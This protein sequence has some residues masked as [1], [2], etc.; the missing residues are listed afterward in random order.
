M[1]KLFISLLLFLTTTTTFAQKI[2]W[3]PINEVEEKI[4]NTN[5]GV[6]G[7]YIG[8]VSGFQYYIYHHPKNQ[9]IIN[10]EIVFSIIKVQN[11]QVIQST[12]FFDK[13]YN[14]LKIKLINNKITVLH[15]DDSDNQIHSVK[16]DIYDPNSLLFEK[17][18][19]LYSYKVISDNNTFY[20][21]V[22]SEDNSKFA[23][24]TPSI[25]PENENGSLFFKVFDIQLNGLFEYHYTILFKGE[26]TLG[27]FKI[28][29]DGIVYFNINNFE[30]G[31]EGDIFKNIY[32]YK[33]SADD[34][35]II[36]HN[37]E[38][39]LNFQ[40]MQY[41]SGIN[42]KGD[43]RFLISDKEKIT[44]Y[45]LDFTTEEIGEGITFDIP[46]GNWSIDKFHSFSN[47]NSVLILADR[48]ITFYS[49][50]SGQCYVFWNRNFLVF[51]FNESGNEIIKQETIYRHFV[52]YERFKS[53]EENLKSSLFFI[54]TEHSISFLYNTNPK[55][56]KDNSSTFY[57]RIGT[58]K[59]ITKIC[60]ISEDGDITNSVVFDSEQEQGVFIPSFSFI[61][62]DS[63]LNIC[64]S[65][66]KK[67]IFGKLTF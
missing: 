48:G 9:F 8:D 40:D 57:D 31:D 23:I 47:G 39:D 5:L 44:F 21:I 30:S 41:I 26:N 58:S 10:E 15:I 64:K 29:N 19:I 56:N 3:G 49:S 25:N 66:K 33:L 46:N 20:K 42:D 28:S 62:S 52:D 14:L 6:S 2:Q 24:L 18:S 38:N 43:V 67:I 59:P 1:K 22:F 12:E 61:S 7:E 36:K 50:Q 34:F 35:R 16:I 54:P 65:L 63:S 17:S 11:N 45:N 55:V 13:K 4:F 60:T 51:N 53:V 37:I 32:F 27:D